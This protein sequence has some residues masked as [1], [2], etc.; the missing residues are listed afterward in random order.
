MHTKKNPQ[1]DVQFFFRKVLI[2]SVRMVCWLLHLILLH[3]VEINTWRR[4]PYFH[5]CKSRIRLNLQRN[6]ILKC[7]KGWFV[8]FSDLRKYIVSTLCLVR[9]YCPRPNAY[10]KFFFSKPQNLS[11]ISRLFSWAFIQI[12]ELWMDCFFSKPS[13]LIS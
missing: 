4:C 1:T 7:M 5:S 13:S 10:L 9:R 8:R 11:F 12:S 6:I 2:Y 3:P